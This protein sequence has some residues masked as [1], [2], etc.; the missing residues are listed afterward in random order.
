MTDFG[1]AYFA[2]LALAAA[3]NGKVKDKFQY[4]DGTLEQLKNDRK[5]RRPDLIKLELPFEEARKDYDKVYAASLVVKAGGGG[6]GNGGASTN[7]GGTGSGGGNRPR[8]PE[9]DR[10]VDLRRGQ[11]VQGDSPS[12]AVEVLLALVHGIRSRPRIPNSILSH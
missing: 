1:V 6:D 9:V 10:G 4:L 12:R 8:E 5:I 3:T 7:G 11:E 2:K